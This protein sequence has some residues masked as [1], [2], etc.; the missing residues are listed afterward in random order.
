MTCKICQK[1]ESQQAMIIYK[2]NYVFAYLSEESQVPG[3][4]IIAPK[5]HYTIFEQ[6]PAKVIEEIFIVANKISLIIVQY[7][8]MGG[9]NVIVNN[10]V[11]AGQE[12]PHFTV[13][14]IPR[15]E[16]DGLEFSWEGK[17]LQDTQLDELG[18]KI[19]STLNSESGDEMNNEKSPENLDKEDYDSNKDFSEEEDYLLRSIDR[20]P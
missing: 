5:K 3:H 8:K 6:A 11:S 18:K 13:D 1:I 20:I 2:G 7:L 4:I 12:I 16:N 19:R 14:V 9:V 15:N 10:G 17:K